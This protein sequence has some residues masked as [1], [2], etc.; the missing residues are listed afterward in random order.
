MSDF[1]VMTWL[2]SLGFMPASSLETKSSLI[3]AS[4]CLIQTFGVDFFLAE[5]IKVYSSVELQETKSGGIYFDPFRG[6]FLIGGELYH[7]NLSIGISHEC[8]HDIVTNLDFH[9]NNGWEGSFEKAYIHYFLPVRTDSGITITPSLTLTNQFVEKLRVKKND[10]KHYFDRLNA[11]VSPN[12][13]SPEFRLETE[14]S[15]L[16]ASA[17]FQ[18]GYAMHKRKW[19][20][21]QLELGAELFYKNIALG[22]AYID[23][24]NRQE[25]AGYSWESLTL[26]VR[27]QGKSS[28]L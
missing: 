10:K 5:H 26:F 9:Q 6:D 20:H 22:V 12:V 15:F 4:D 11:D 28:L 16:R 2:L 8:N 18:A 19:T 17:A 1:L 21:T 13:F 23:R 7:K 27:F 14:F 25:N 24:N 3:Q